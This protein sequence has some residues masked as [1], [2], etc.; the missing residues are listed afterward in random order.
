MQN[1]AQEFG[2]FMN[3]GLFVID[4]VESASSDL[5]REFKSTKLP[6]FRSYPN[7]KEGDEKRKASFEIIIPKNKAMEK[8]QE[9]VLDEVIEAFDSDVKNVDEKAYHSLGSAN[10]KDG[11]VTVLLMYEGYIPFAYRGLAAHPFLKDDFV[12]MATDNLTPYLLGE[13]K[14]PA[15]QGLMPIDEENPTPRVFRFQ[16]MEKLQYNEG[17]KALLNMFP[18]KMKEY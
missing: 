17:L 2:D 1:L 11:K 9:V 5:K 3:F 18:E 15:I 4:D 13:D 16:G 14:P 6:L 7:G 8:I 12:F 10:S